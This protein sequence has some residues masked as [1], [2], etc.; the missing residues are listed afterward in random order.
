MAM[1]DLDTTRRAVLGGVGAAAML[2]T[3]TRA[4]PATPLVINV[5]DVAGNLAL[6]QPAFEA[7]RRKFPKTVSRFVFSK[8]P[9]PELPAKLR[10]QQ[11]AKRVDIDIVLTGTDGLSAGMEQKSWETLFPNQA[12]KLPDLDNIL[13]P[14][15]KRMQTLAE[16]Q[17]CIIAY[18]PSGPLLEYM[19]AKVSQVPQTAE[20]LLAWC[21]A[22]PKRFMYAR[23]ANSGPG[24]TFMMGLPYLLGD[25]A[26]RDPMNGWAKTWAYLAAMGEFIEYYPSGTGATMKELGE[27]SRDMIV[28]TTGWDINPRVLGVVPKEAE[29]AALRGFH[30][31]GDAHF[32]AIPKGLPPERLAVLLDVV[33][34]LLRKESQAVTYDRGYFY[35]GPCVA[36]VTL[37][38]A[39]QESQDDIREF[40]RPIYDKLIAEVP[41]ELPLDA[42]KMVLAF[43]RWDEQVGVKTAK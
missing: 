24:R 9:A 4:Q 1:G 32:A 6:S 39:P 21:R 43:R 25:S 18:Y 13:L 10:A 8:A 27:G 35:P 30:W 33:S 11:D 40:G 23:P 5:V 16:N 28:S 12:S 31:I 20:D 26:P 2:A 19:P 37:D 36:D 42:D 34:H 41:V 38:M 14:A 7:Y 15:A 29:M 3:A 17:G 22:N